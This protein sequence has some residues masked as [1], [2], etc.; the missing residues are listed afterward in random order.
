MPPPGQVWEAMSESIPPPVI[1]RPAASL[2]LLRGAPGAPEVLMGL[3]GARHVFMPNRLVFP[4]GAVDPEDADAPC[5][6][7][8]PDHALRR[9]EKSAS[10]ALARALGHAVARELEEETDLSLGRPPALDGLDF[11]C[12]AVTP[13]RAPIRF[14]ARFFVADAARAT[15]TL[16]GD[17]EL[18]ALCWYKVEDALALDLATPTRGV[19]HRLLEWLAIPA[20]DRPA[21][22]GVPVMLNR[23]WSVE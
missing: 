19:L 16:G 4:G 23:V 9:L 10:P 6:T 20:P 13:E 8:L 7:G 14:D 11:L 21:R 3:R 22:A 17:G 2:L 18:E 15:G 1:P 12:R 5:A